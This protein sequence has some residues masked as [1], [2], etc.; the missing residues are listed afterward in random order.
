MFNKTKK[1]P[2]YIF[3]LIK[4]NKNTIILIRNCSIYRGLVCGL[5]DL[6]VKI[7]GKNIYFF[8]LKKLNLKQNKIFRFHLM[9]FY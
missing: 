6:C 5:R 7:N 1:M 2:I 4:M 3:Y 8:N 9:L